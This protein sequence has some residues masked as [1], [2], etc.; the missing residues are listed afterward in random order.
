MSVIVND[1]DSQPAGRWLSIQ[2]AARHLSVS[3]RTIYRRADR[4]QL[5]RRSHQDGHVEVWVPPTAGG[6][7][8]DAAS[9]IDSQARALALVDRLGEAVSRQVAPLMAE[10]TTSREQIADLARENGRLQEQVAALERELTAV[11][12]VTD[13]RLWQARVSQGSHQT[14]EDWILTTQGPEPP[15]GA[16]RVRAAVYAV[17]EL[18]GTGRQ[19]RAVLAALVG[20]AQWRG[21]I[22]GL[23][24]G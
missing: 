2:E 6:D 17:A 8:S 15:P 16:I 1:S 24:A 21:L 13:I 18:A 14:L 4:G 7:M 11:R 22:S 23:G 20:C 19:P 12:Q 5:R 10:L 9:D 3:E